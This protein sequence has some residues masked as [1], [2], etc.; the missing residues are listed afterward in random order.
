MFQRDRSKSEPHPWQDAL[1]FYNEIKDYVVH[2]HVKDCRYPK[3]GESEPDYTMPGEG[4][5]HLR[6]ILRDFKARHY[7]GGIAI[8]PH[9]A[10][11]FHLEEGEEPDWKQCF[12]SY[13]AYGARLEELL[14]EMSWEPKDA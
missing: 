6:E 3:L 10:T 2:V 14:D 12:N 9:V 8:E 7:D 11:V 13:V 4:D 5:A 1:G